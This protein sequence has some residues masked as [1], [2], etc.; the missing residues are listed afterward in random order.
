MITYSRV[1]LGLVV[2]VWN[3]G[4]LGVTPADVHVPSIASEFIPCPAWVVAGASYDGKTFVNPK[5][6]PAAPKLFPIVIENVTGD[7]V[8]FDNGPNEFTCLLG[9]TVTF[10]GPLAIPD[11][12]FRVPCA[13]TDTGRTIFGVA[14]V[15]AGVMTITVTFPELGK[16]QLTEAMVNDGLPQ[17]LFALSDPITCVVI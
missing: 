8:G 3:D 7:E 1:Q 13:M 2:E 16:W 12:K 11:R 5:S 4:G 17:P 15:A 9:A 10:T 6:S 14:D